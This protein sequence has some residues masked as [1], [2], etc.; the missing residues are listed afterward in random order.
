MISVVTPS[1]RQLEWLRLC[2]ASVADQGG[3][4]CEHL[5]QD[6][7]TEGL[8]EALAEFPALLVIEK[9]DGMY[10]AINR[11]LRRTTGE[12]C[13]YLNCDEQY[14]PGALLRVAQYFRAHPQVEVLFGDA[15]II[16][17]QGRALTYR[18]AISPTRR[19]LRAS[20]LNVYTCATFFRRSV[21]E[22]GH[23]LDPKWKS[24]GDVIWIDRML[25]SGIRMAILPELLSTFTLTGGN[26]S[27][28]NPISEDE[29]RR[30][31]AEVGELSCAGRAQQVIGHRLRKLF[32][33]AYRKRTFDYSIY[34]LRSPR[35]RV[36]LRAKAIGGTWPA[37][38]T[39]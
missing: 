6:A 26:L 8:A 34:T 20:H 35:A 1:F 23:V 3:V 28:D 31:R 11:G 19:H 12:I 27:T 17:S 10:D 5:V 38:G 36:R 37:S 4:S 14:L 15:L 9:D 18:R 13:A 29:K 22:A 21:I 39:R 25:A 30:W 33:G 24:I 2:V 32:A 7:G 16:D